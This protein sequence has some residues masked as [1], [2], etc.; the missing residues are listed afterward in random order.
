MFSFLFLAL[1]Y[2]I[3]PA[4]NLATGNRMRRTQSLFSFGFFVSRFSRS[5]PFVLSRLGYRIVLFVLAVLFCFLGTSLYLYSGSFL[6][7]FFILCF[8]CFPV[9][10]PVYSCC[11]VPIF[12]ITQWTFHEQIASKQCARELSCHRRQTRNAG[13]WHSG[14]IRRGLGALRGDVLRIIRCSGGSIFVHVPAPPLA[15]AALIGRRR[16]MLL[17][18]PSSFLVL[19]PTVPPAINKTLFP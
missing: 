5:N 8:I 2:L 4:S 16:S 6:L 15:H 13:A 9:F 18:L 17:C 11:L 19:V 1:S 10:Q 14:P 12:I 3:S 7:F